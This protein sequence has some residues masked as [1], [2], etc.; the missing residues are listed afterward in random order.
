MLRAQSLV[1]CDAG[2]VGG[3]AIPVSGC[4]WTNLRGLGWVRC[5]RVS[6]DAHAQESPAP[7]AVPV[8]HGCLSSYRLV[9]QGGDVLFLVPVRCAEHHH[10]ILKGG[11][12]PEPETQI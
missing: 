11:K 1:Y 4:A 10:S 2:A 8:V 7:P 5:P 6:E 3:R 12:G 9:E